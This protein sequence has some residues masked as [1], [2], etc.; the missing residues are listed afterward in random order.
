[1]PALHA[2]FS[3]SHRSSSL[4]SGGQHAARPSQRGA[5]MLEFIFAGSL[6]SLIGTVA[7]QYVLMFNAKNIVNHAGF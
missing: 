6:I 5:A 1:M 2:A 3:A 7:L 4:S